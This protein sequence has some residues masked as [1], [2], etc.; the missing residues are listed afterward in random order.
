MRM[1]KRHE[2]H[3]PQVTRMRSTHRELQFR[4]PGIQQIESR[5]P[6]HHHLRAA[7]MTQPAARR[8]ARAVPGE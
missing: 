7:S 8:A 5:S 3:V 1:D 6:P 2:R 4:K